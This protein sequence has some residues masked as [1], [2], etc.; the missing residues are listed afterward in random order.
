MTR[1]EQ[2][3]KNIKTFERMISIFNILLICI[4]NQEINEKLIYTKNLVKELK[5]NYELYL[6]QE[7][8][9]LFNKIDNDLFTINNL[10]NELKEDI[11]NKFK[12]VSI[13]YLDNLKDEE[14]II[15]YD[16][17]NNILKEHHNIKNACEYIYYHSGKE[18]SEFITK[19]LN[20]INKNIPNINNKKIPITYLENNKNIVTIYYKEWIDLFKQLNY[21]M[22]YIADE[23]NQ[24]YLLLK[25]EYQILLVYYF[26]VITEGQ[27]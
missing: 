15:F 8:I 14:L 24:D 7:N 23:T 13:V 6:E 27:N 10:I 3:N 25:Q 16:N 20:Y 4:D 18:I 2:I 17:L 5:N 11:F 9:I 22:K 12:L 21:T 1:I 19:L 26:I